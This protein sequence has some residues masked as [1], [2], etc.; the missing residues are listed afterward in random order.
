VSPGAVRSRRRTWLV[1]TGI[2][3]LLLLALVVALTQIIMWTTIPRDVVLSKLQTQL[4]LRIQARNLSAGWLGASLRDVRISLPLAEQSVVEVPE[5]RVRYNWLPLL[6]LL[7]PD[8]KR[9]ELD[10]PVLNVWQS[11]DGQWNIAEVAEL[12]GRAGGKN[13]DSARDTGG[14]SP[15]RLP[16]LVIA[17]ATV[18]VAAAGG[19]K[20]RIQHVQVRGET[21]Q[22]TLVWNYDVSIAG[23]IS[24]AGKVAPGD[25]WSNVVTVNIK[26]RAVELLRPWVANVPAFELVDGKWTGQLDN[27]GLSGRLDIGMIK[28]NGF[29]AS[30]GL[31]ASSQNGTIQ[32]RPVNLA[33]QTGQAALPRVVATGGALSFDGKN[34]VANGVQA[35]LAGGQLRIDATIDTA[36]TVGKLSMLWEGLTISPGGAADGPRTSGSLEASIATRLAGHPEIRATL[37]T[38]GWLSAT[39]NWDGSLQVAGDGASWQ[40]ISWGITASNLTLNGEQTLQLNGLNALLRSK[41]P[42]LAL[43]SI[44]LPEAS[45]GRVASPFRDAV[46]SADDSAAIQ[47]MI[48]GGGPPATTAPSTYANGRRQPTAA[49]PTTRAADPVPRR[50][51]GSAD[52]N[53]ATGAWWLKLSGQ[54]WPAPQIEDETF[55]FNV[56]AHGNPDILSLNDLSFILADAVV[57]VHGTYVYAEPAPVHMQLELT[58]QQGAPPKNSLEIQR[59]E[60]VSAVTGVPPASV[61][62][63]D[64]INGDIHG[65][66]NLTGTMKD[67][68][69]LRIKGKLHGRDVRIRGLKIGDFDGNI[70]GTADQAL[71]KV[72][73]DKFDLLG[74]KWGLSAFYQFDKDATTVG[75]SVDKLRLQDPRVQSLLRRN[76]LAGDFDGQ[77]NLYM[78]GIKSRSERLRGTGWLAGSNLLLPNFA[79]SDV[80]ANFK[81]EDGNLTIDPI[82]LRRPAIEV[83]GSVLTNEVRAAL[84]SATAPSDPAG[85]TGKIDT[86]GHIS[87]ALAMNLAHR[88]HIT[89]SR[90][91]FVR[92]PYP[93]PAAEAALSLDGG[94][95]SIIID[96]PDGS[97][98]AAS[99]GSL[100]HLNSPSIVVTASILTALTN[101]TAAKVGDCDLV[102]QLEDRVADIR[103]L[104]MN[105]LGARLNANAL[106]DLD[107][108]LLASARL[109]VQN[110]DF[111]QI[112]RVV[113][114]A[115]RVQ[116]KYELT[117]GIAPARGPYALEPLQIDVSMR[118]IGA[119]V[120]GM[121][122]GDGRLRAFANVDPDWGLVRLVSQD[123]PTRSSAG[124]Q[125]CPPV[126][127]NPAEPNQNTL[128]MAG[129]M[130]R[131]WARFV[132]NENEAGV[133]GATS[134]SSHISLGF[135][136]LELN[137]LAHIAD[138]ESPTM[139]GKLDGAIDLYGTTGI[140]MPKGS[141]VPAGTDPA[142]TQPAAALAEKDPFM[143]RLARSLYGDGKVNLSN[144][145]IGNFG[146]IAFLYN[147]MHIGNDKR[148]PT[149]TGDVSFRI[150]GGSMNVTSLHY[151]NRGV[152]VRA[153]ARVDDLAAVPDCPLSGTAVGSAR[154]LKN[155]K[156][157]IFSS[158][159]PDVDSLLSALQG[160]TISERF[161][162]TLHKPKMSIIV[163]GEL[164]EA[165]KQFLVGDVRAETQGSAGQ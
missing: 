147:A 129:G 161:G 151:F 93:I 143:V 89:L 73:T 44:V 80:H 117:V 142:A 51:S 119:R 48:A 39:R 37:N 95:D 11:T 100:L 87:L 21:G 70:D 162:G 81:L 150:E 24:L 94:S 153:I 156:L 56:D 60:A 29:I 9:I 126:R 23:D 61:P 130:L 22:S 31:N 42:E 110:V 123:L 20:Q 113:P 137:Q 83:A 5:M 121:E 120:G 50:L 118:S 59:A 54:G 124:D 86:N 14:S 105:L 146:P 49:S 64:L 102:M 145:D 107:H 75:L 128:E 134:L 133:P 55:G 47:Q 114:A 131:I 148:G 10:R 52:Y 154:P 103:D 111:K 122:L 104:Q 25:I 17:D 16:A 99:P 97:G 125:K 65:N 115:Q 160:S 132:R 116:G 13:T 77:W 141:G 45:T 28:V 108:P 96:L 139:P 27:G 1:R 35:T 84:S 26:P 159:L 67:R 36:V 76:D 152:E 72:S 82:E 101:T 88:N 7:G 43:T 127:D 74:A 15:P 163:F 3:V 32:I 69:D 98:N 2:V 149:G 79:A 46:A 19:K 63:T 4:G 18:N 136:C 30:G 92:W 155:V 135:K 68:L 106:L 66:V 140:S 58:H 53:L 62:D 85:A 90:L 112:A 8:L 38:R 138:V 144:A 91:S 78:P 71:A 12:L 158:I 41:G 109:W 57:R 165:M 40:D 34:V 33:V 6:L 164:G 157:P